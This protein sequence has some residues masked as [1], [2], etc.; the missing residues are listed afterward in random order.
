ML[1]SFMYS[2]IGSG[3]IASSTDLYL[4]RRHQTVIEQKI[5]FKKRD[6]MGIQ[7]DDLRAL[8]ISALMRCLFASIESAPGPGY[9]DQALNNIRLDE[10]FRK[11]TEL[12]SS[13]GWIVANIGTKY[14][15][16]MRYVMRMDPTARLED[17][18]NLLKYEILSIVV[19]RIVGI[20]E[21]KIRNVN[22]NQEIAVDEQ[23]VL[24]HVAIMC[25]TMIS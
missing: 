15:Q 24:C 23:I 3:F 19:R 7:N 8:S 18:K 21:V 14:L 10:I 5:A 22:N 17:M 9:F 11:I 1:Q 25:N 12:C 6:Q 16:V 13:T 4:Q 2:E 20:L